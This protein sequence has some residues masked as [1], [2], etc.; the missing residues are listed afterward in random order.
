MNELLN[1]IIDHFGSQA[2]LARTLKIKSMAITNWRKRKSIPAIRA[3]QIQ[4]ITK[5][6]FKASNIIELCDSDDTVIVDSVCSK[7]RHPVGKSRLSNRK[8]VG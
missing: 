6:K 1:K 7:S 4:K 2:N 8:R 5:G 3:Y